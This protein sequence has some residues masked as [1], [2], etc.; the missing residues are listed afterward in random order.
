MKTITWLHVTDLHVGQDAG[1]LWPN[2]RQ[3]VFDDLEKLAEQT[4]PVDLVFFTGDIVQGGE[5]SEFDHAEKELA[6]LRKLFARLGSSPRI[7]FVPGNHDLK[8]PDSNSAYA[9]ASHSWESHTKIVDEFW[10]NDKFWLRKAV[11]KSFRNYESWVQKSGDTDP[12]LVKGILPGD[13]S[14][15]LDIRGIRVGVL[16]LNTTYLQVDKGDYTAKLDV[17]LR[18]VNVLTGSDPKGWR[19]GLDIAV[20]LT[21]QPPSWLRPQGRIVLKELLASVSIHSHFCG[22]LHTPNVRDLS[23]FGGPVQRL[24]Q[25][26]SLF[27]L[28]RC[29]NNPRGRFGYAVGQWLFSPDGPQ[30]FYWPRVNTPG[31]DGINRISADTQMAVDVMGR[32]C[33]PLDWQERTGGISSAIVSEPTAESRLQIVSVNK[34]PDELDVRAKLKG[35]PRYAPVLK[36]EHLAIRREERDLACQLLNEKTPLWLVA[37]WRSG[38][39]GF[40]ATLIPCILKASNAW[41]DCFR[42]HCGQVKDTDDLLAQA[43]SQLG[44]SFQEF[45]AAVAV[46]PRALL[47]LE[48]LP[49]HLLEGTAMSSFQSKIASIFDFGEELRLVFVVRK[50]PAGIPRNHIVSLVPLDPEAVK[51]YLLN[52][53]LARLEIISALNVERIHDWSGGLPAHLDRLLE[54]IPHV[55]LG[56]ILNDEA[57]P[58]NS[59]VNEP[60]PESLK[61]AVQTLEESD[62]L[63]ESRALELLKVLTILKDGETLDSI[64]RFDKKP[65][66]I[67]HVRVLISKHL[68]E[69]V[70]ISETIGNLLKGRGRATIGN[71]PPKFL[72]VPRQVRD[73]V[74]MIL[75]D[76]ERTEIEKASMPLLFGNDWWKNK[77]RYRA[78]LMRVYQHS[79]L[80]GPG[81]EHVIV[82]RLLERAMAR[83][84]GSHVKKYAQVALGYCHRLHGH[85]RFRDALIAAS[86]LTEVFRGSS[87]VKEFLEACSMQA[88]CLR[89]IGHYEEAVS[90]F[91]EALDCV[92]PE[93]GHDFTGSLHLG[94]AQCYR[95]I[96]ERRTEAKAAAERCLDFVDK[97]SED[98]F[99]ARALIAQLELQGLAL[100]EKLEGLEAGARGKKHSTTANNIAIVLANESSNPSESLRWLNKVL[101]TGQDFYNRVRAIVEKIAIVGERVSVRELVSSDVDL[102]QSAYAYAYSQR[103]GNLMERCHKV[104]WGLFVRG[105]LYAPL[106]RM[107]RFSSFVWRLRDKSKLEEQ[108]IYELV[109]VETRQ[110]APGEMAT[111]HLEWN[112]LQRRKAAFAPQELKGVPSALHRKDVSVGPS[113][114]S[115]EDLGGSEGQGE[116]HTSKGSEYSEKPGPLPG[117]K[118]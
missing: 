21:H 91:E 16:G 107:F 4:G 55:S 27:G 60:P 40:L 102:L 85:D 51:E 26:V 28:D 24:R 96:P 54:N 9:M 115:L 30:E 112:Y 39:D 87:F 117:P 37:D 67:N 34:P 18:Q 31:L 20:L 66:R 25:G 1:W 2:M 69:E 113:S 75:T 13:F 36:K 14:A 65:F 45:A 53:E 73:Y 59:A 70:P 41:P 83:G 64:K 11:K 58:P 74:N 79:A 47:I 6:N 116:E 33:S 93:L 8:R 89:M 110:I 71:E 101:L 92:C 43:E 17:D 78:S 104:L 108:Y 81:N 5:Q 106:V 90:L 95:L 82:R 72:K 23:E 10:S 105:G 109:H 38:A 35:V 48:D 62:D 100:K 103:I 86:S 84:Q 77:I 97:E 80:Q 111:L 88:K 46:L 118:A 12:S 61:R 19:D 7:L 63:V 57:E 15:K 3:K 114:L 42:L 49:A 99:Q 32:I 44:L 68:L 50:A 22:H 94:V 76:D 56:A 98:G 52:H 29:E